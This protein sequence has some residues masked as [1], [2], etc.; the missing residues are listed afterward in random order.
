MYE[1]HTSLLSDV[2][3]AYLQSGYRAFTFVRD[4][5]TRFASAWQQVQFM[6]RFYKHP[7]DIVH[8]LQNKN[9]LLLLGPSF[10]F[11][12]SAN[13]IKIY[14]LENFRQSIIEVLDACGYP[15]V[16]WNRNERHVMENKRVDAAA[17]YTAHPDLIKF[18][19]EF[20]FKDFV[21]LRYPMRIVTDPFPHSIPNFDSKLK[22]DWKDV[23]SNTNDL[24]YWAM[25]SVYDQEQ[26]PPDSDLVAFPGASGPEP[27][28]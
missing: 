16:W 24:Y 27:P 5:Y 11:T 7:D 3:Q 1:F 25:K 13:S 18:V 23:K 14:K 2:A 22:Y 9:Y 21:D 20:Y 26:D 8:Q 10:F 4:P 28:Q 15:R 12:G 6:T 19:T 17:F